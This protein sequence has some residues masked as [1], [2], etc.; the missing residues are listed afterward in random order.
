[1]LRNEIPRGPV[2]EPLADARLRAKHYRQ[3]RGALTRGT[4]SAGNDGT[5]KNDGALPLHAASL[6][7]LAVIGPNA[8]T[9]DLGGYSNVAAHT[10]SVLEGIKA[11]VGNRVHIVSAEGV[12][13][14]DKGNW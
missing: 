9:V 12:R 10:V 5:L 8:A 2:R 11:K 13:I 4:S 6:K 14:T 1:M 3:R 7:T